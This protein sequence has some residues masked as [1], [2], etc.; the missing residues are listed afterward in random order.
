MRQAALAIAGAGALALLPGFFLAPNSH[1]LQVLTLAL[2]FAAMAQSWNL[3]G[4]L[5]NQMSLG[6]AAFFGVGAYTSTLLLVHFGLSPWVGMIAA[7]ALGGALAFLVSL[8]TMWLEGHYFALAT[9]AVGE[10]LRTIANSWATLTGGPGG[11]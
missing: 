6:H 9:L 1:V 8:P 4:G 2:L 5:A 10:V 3:V 11:L 7:A